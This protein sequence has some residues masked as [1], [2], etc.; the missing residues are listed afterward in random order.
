MIKSLN[1]LR[2]ASS[3]ARAFAWTVGFA[4][5]LLSAR[6]GLSDTAPQ[7]TTIA[8]TSGSSLSDGSDLTYTFSVT[9]GTYPIISISVDVIDPNGYDYLI[10]GN[11]F[12][13]TIADTTS[14]NWVNGSYTVKGINIVDSHGV[15]EYPMGGTITNSGGETVGTINPLSPSLN[16][17]LTGGAA[18]ITGPSI[19]SF[20]P[21][22]S[23]LFRPMGST[24]AFNIGLNPG[25]RN[26]VSEIE[27]SVENTSEQGSDLLAT[28]SLTGSRVTFP[29]TGL[30]ELGP[31][32]VSIVSIGDGYGFES[33]Q[34]ASGPNA[35][36]E[37]PGTANI[38]FLAL[39]FTLTAAPA[40]IDGDGNPDIFWT[41]TSTAQ[42]GAYLM[43][44]TRSVG[45]ANLW[46]VDR[47]WRI[48][49]VADFTG[50]GKNDI[51][52]ENTYTGECGFY[53]MN[54]TTVTS[55]VEL[56]T[57]S[58]AWHAVA[59]ADFECNGNNDIV[60]QN[61]TTGECGIYLMN[62][63]TV[64][65]WAELGIVDP[66]WRI[67]GA[68]DFN[69]DGYPD[70]LWQNTVTGQCGIYLM[71]GTTVT[72]WASLGT[73]PTQW[74]AVAVGYF[75][76]NGNTDIL[77]QNTGTGECGFYLMNGTTVTGWS[78]LGT[79]PTQWQVQQ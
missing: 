72:G 8:L 42:R 54:G 15:T 14:T 37:H 27:V 7:L 49:A 77:W 32:F 17:T 12:N 67:A 26:Q 2:L 16:F 53:L 6:A 63:T 75:S 47:S 39:D 18:S 51:L 25:T 23:N 62:G 19:T 38:D 5:F 40:D 44:G 34:P 59:A 71:N 41:N 45:W 66:S 33:F 4:L 30:T 11:A 20:T 60:W 58:P 31:Y 70:I 64:T 56:G 46:T 28:G 65:G 10:A 21:L 22:P 13:G 68:A 78:E 76:G 52:W 50:N 36:I 61:T 24:L 3:N 73:V 43:N 35:I 57:M 1:Y 9:Q 74:Q 29:I 79:V 69:G 48:C 55:W